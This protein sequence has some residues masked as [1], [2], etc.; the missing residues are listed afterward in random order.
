MDIIDQIE[1]LVMAMYRRG[2]EIGPFVVLGSRKISEL[3][4]YMYTTRIRQNPHTA[5][6]GGIN[7]LTIQTS[8][9]RLD[10][11]VDKNK[12]ADYIGINGRT[13]LDIIVEQELLGL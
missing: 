6:A 11:K 12:P 13:L 2:E 7:S 8:Y 9:G 10:I 1:E 3:Y 4:K 5:V